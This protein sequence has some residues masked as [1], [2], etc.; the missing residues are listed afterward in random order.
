MY[1]APMPDSRRLIFRLADLFEG[2]VARLALAMM[3]I[4][5]LLPLGPL[6]LALR[7]IFL[8]AFGAELLVRFLVLRADIH[9]TRA[10]TIAEVGL[11][12]KP[13]TGFPPHMPN[14]T[15]LPGLIAILAKC[16]CSPI[17]ANMGRARS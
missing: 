1:D 8:M 7:P 5:S 12:G 10:V 17:P 9:G 16:S 4:V 14:H 3:V 2:R 13:R 15:G 11:P 6:D